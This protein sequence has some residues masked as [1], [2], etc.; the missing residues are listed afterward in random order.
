MS[1]DDPT[2]TAETQR[3]TDNDTHGDEE[4]PEDFDSFWTGDGGDE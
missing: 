3:A 4:L 1:A 2:T